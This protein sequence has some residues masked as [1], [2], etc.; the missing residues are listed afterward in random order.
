MASKEK[1]I[2]RKSVKEWGSVMAPGSGVMVNKLTPREGVIGSE[3]GIDSMVIVWTNR[4]LDFLENV[5]FK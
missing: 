1:K 4:F 3:G 5:L 2:R